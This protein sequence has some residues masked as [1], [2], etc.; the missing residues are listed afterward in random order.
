VTVRSRLLVLSL[1]LL[2]PAVSAS[3]AGKPHPPRLAR[4]PGDLA[5]RLQAARAE[6][7]RTTREVRESLQRVLLLDERDVAGTAEAVERRQ[8]L[9]EQGVLTDAELEASARELDDARTRLRETRGLIARADFLLAEVEA[10]DHIARLP[11]LALGAYAVSPALIR[12]NGPAGWSLRSVG[13]VGRFFATRFGRPLPISAF[14][15]TPAHDRMAFDHRDALDVAVEPDSTE[16]QAL[17]AYLRESGIPFL[18][19]RHAVPR[20]ATGAHV[21]VGY[22]SGRLTARAR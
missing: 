20:A 8:R 18:A 10:A 16:G 7:I 1:A 6:V 9:H 11:R 3:G 12:Y 17:M 4:S 2:L 19:F 5:R 21:H 14:G 13:K 15:Q 22:P